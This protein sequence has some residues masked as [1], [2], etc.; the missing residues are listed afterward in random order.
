VIPVRE[1]WRPKPA[2]VGIAAL[3]LVLGCALGPRPL[4]DED[5]IIGVRAL[6]TSYR[7]KDPLRIVGPTGREYVLPVGEYRPRG[8]D[9]AGILYEAPKGVMERAGFS[10]RPLPGGVYV[11]NAPGRPYESPSL[12]IERSRGRITRLP[13]PAAALSRY[14]DALVFAVDGEEQRP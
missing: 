4:S 6:D 14:G 7:V 5:T 11:A 8:A 13:L 10:R 9:A 2:L 12:W 1:G 3:L